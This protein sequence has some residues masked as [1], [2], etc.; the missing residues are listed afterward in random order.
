MAIDPQVLDRIYRAKEERRK[1]LARRPF[2]EK[3]EMLVTMQKR[4]VGA[5]FWVELLDFERV[6]RRLA[7]A[8]VERG[9]VAELVERFGL[10][11]SWAEFT[12]RY[13]ELA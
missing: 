8:P 9:E 12:R 13:P 2:H 10:A 5:I 4:A 1:E 3:I 7:E 6:R 11:E